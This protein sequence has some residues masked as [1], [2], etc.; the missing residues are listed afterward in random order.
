MADIFHLERIFKNTSLTPTDKKILEFILSN[1]QKVQTHG[2]RSLAVA[3]FTS[4]A[5]IERLAKKL[6]YSGYSE[7]LFQAKHIAATNAVPQSTDL[8]NF[9]T[10]PQRDLELKIAQLFDRKHYFYIYGEGFNEFVT[11]YIYRKFLVTHFP[12][13][14][15]SGLEIPL[16]Y[17]EDQDPVLLLISRSGENFACLQKIEQIEQV[18][19]ALI[20]LTANPNSTIAKKSD[21]PIFIPDTRL[22][23]SANIN[24]TTFF[25]DCINAFE[26]LLNFSNQQ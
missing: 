26:K 20:S 5:S 25:G 24:Y 2:I 18:N 22:S 11:G 13:L 4:P 1:P 8:Y 3:T 9:T 14:L 12:A 10:L 23:D 16:V 6:G 21:V 15:L 7:L 17:E 19:G